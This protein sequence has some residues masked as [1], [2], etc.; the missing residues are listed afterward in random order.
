MTKII[1]IFLLIIPF[2]TGCI[3]QYTI[4]DIYE[5]EAQ[6]DE[7]NNELYMCKQAIDEANY[8]IWDAKNW[9]WSSYEEMGNA[10]DS[11]E[12]IYY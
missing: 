12:E 5:L 1:L 11:L 8:N 7:L 3:S 4:D 2:L 10:L 6:I 9:A